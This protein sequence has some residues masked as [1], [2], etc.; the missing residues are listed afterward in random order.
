MDALVAG[1]N[2]LQYGCGVPHLAYLTVVVDPSTCVPS[3]CRRLSRRPWQVVTPG[4]VGCAARSHIRVMRAFSAQPPSEPGV[5]PFDAPGSL[6][7]YAVCA[8]G[9]E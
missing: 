3:P 6:A 5:H 7:I 4:R 9:L 2:D 8:T 1:A